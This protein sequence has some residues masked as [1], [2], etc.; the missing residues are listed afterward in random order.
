V[1]VQ[2]GQAHCPIATQPVGDDLPRLVSETGQQALE[3]ALGSRGLPPLLDQD[4]EHDAVLVHR[5][6][7]IVQDAI[8]P[9]KHLIKM[10]GITRLRPVSPQLPGQI[11][12]PS[13]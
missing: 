9:W 1:S 7:E 11:I 2:A 13:I 10:P 5:A 3:E 8:D 6:P 4:V 12:P